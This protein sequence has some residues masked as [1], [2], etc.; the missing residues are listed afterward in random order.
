M[1]P[2]ALVVGGTGPTRPHVVGGL[3]ARGFAVT[4][5]HTGRYERDEISD[6]VEHVHTDP[7]HARRRLPGL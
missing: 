4:M 7:F 6:V 3:V 1:A 2:P 5:L